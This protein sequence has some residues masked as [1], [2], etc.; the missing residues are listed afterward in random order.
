MQTHLFIWYKLQSAR[1]VSLLRR[2]TSQFLPQLHC[3]ILTASSWLG[4]ALCLAIAIGILWR[5]LLVEHLVHLVLVF[6]INELSDI[7]EH[8]LY[9]A[10]QLCRSLLEVKYLMFLLEFQSFFKAN[11]SL[12]F[13]IWFIGDQTHEHIL[14]AGSSC[15]LMPVDEVLESVSL[16]DSISKN[17]S[18]SSSVEDLSDWPKAL[19]ACSVPDLKL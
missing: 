12:A 7:D 3:L 6:Q 10:S 8:L 2:L 19:L 5:R 4:L 18:M 17:C 16:C 9:V 1:A 15:L 14:T 11:L 13:K